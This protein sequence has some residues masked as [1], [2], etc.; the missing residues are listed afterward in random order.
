MMSA[1]Q[2]PFTSNPEKNTSANFI[3]KAVT[4]RRTKNDNNQKVTRFRGNLIKN[5]TVAL[6][7]PTTMAT[8]IAVP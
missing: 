3:I 6:R 7:S 4:K 8:P 2:K 1:G 5:P